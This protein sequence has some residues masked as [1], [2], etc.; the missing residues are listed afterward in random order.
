MSIKKLP[1]Y[2]QN[3]RRIR[4]YNIRKRDN[5]IPTIQD[6]MSFIQRA[7]DEANDSVFGTQSTDTGSR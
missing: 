7:A 6:I 2:L 5:K 4:A 1:G 3:K